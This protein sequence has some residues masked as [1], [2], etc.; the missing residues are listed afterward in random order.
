VFPTPYLAW[1]LAP[2][3]HGIPE[4]LNIVEQNTMIG[5]IEKEKKKKQH[6]RKRHIDIRLYVAKFRIENFSISN[7][8]ALAPITNYA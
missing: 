6:K 3:S 2:K 4:A 7:K 5:I 8:K 1:K